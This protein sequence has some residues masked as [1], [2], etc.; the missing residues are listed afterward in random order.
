MSE[1]SAEWTGRHYLHGGTVKITATDGVITAIEEQLSSTSDLWISPGL[2]DVQLNGIQGI[3]FNDPQT[4]PEQILQAVR[5]LHVR[6][7][8]HFCP[9]VVTSDSEGMSTCIR[10]I[11]QACDRYDEVRYSVL[12][13]HVEGPY[14]SDEDGPRG[15]HSREYVRDPDWREFAAW[16]QL[17][18]NRIRMLTLAPER[19][20]AVAFIERLTREGVVAAIGHTR[21]TEAELDQAVVAGAA[22][23]THLGNGAHPVIPRHPNYIWSQLA[24]DRL[25]AGLIAD[26]H[27][28]PPATLKSM[29][30]AKGEKAILVSDANHFEGFPPGRYL[31]RRQHEVLLD[32]DG[33]LVMAD[34]P[35]IFSGAATP[36]NRCVENVARFGICPLGEAI[37]MASEHPAR[38]LGAS[39]RGTG[40]LAVGAPADLLLYEQ[41]ADRRFHIRAAV[42]QGRTVYSH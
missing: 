39:A 42:S 14:I 30:R 19:K 21:A 33:R 41:S 27:H 18:G 2:I 13:I 5:Y 16:Q 3:D 31:K 28:L 15:A 17:S 7:V 24:D 8:V 1:Q 22:M 26:G 12:G 32:A 10:T 40:R 6:G 36:L 23:S 4:S 38:M 37:R 34:N 9:T 11:G 25:W 35:A 29:I 20:G